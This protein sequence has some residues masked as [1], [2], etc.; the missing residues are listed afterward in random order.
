MPTGLTGLDAALLGAMFDASMFPCRPHA[1]TTAAVDHIAGAN[2]CG[3][4]EAWTAL[5]RLAAPWLLPMPL[6]SSHG[7]VGTMYD[8][9]TEPRFTECRLTNAGQ[10]AVQSARQQI[11]TLPIGLI[12][13]EEHLT[14]GTHFDLWP[15]EVDGAT[16][17]LRPGFRPH[18]IID[19]LRRVIADPTVA[20]DEIVELVGEPWLGAF[21][22]PREPLDQLL[23]TGNQ[24]VRLTPLRSDDPD[25]GKWA[26]PTADVALTIGRPLPELLRNWLQSVDNRTA[27]TIAGLDQLDALLDPDS[28]APLPPPT[29][30]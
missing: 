21:D 30:T 2:A 8:P 4:A 6:V 19:G 16:L 22:R 10:L 11:A 18:R 26:Y 5:Q 9:A 7:N 14:L 28:I 23:Q 20:D 27:A 15:T 12:N 25:E 29:A 3:A 1:R 24:T 17:R 13:G